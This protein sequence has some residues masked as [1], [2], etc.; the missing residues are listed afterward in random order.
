MAGIGLP[1]G[2]DDVTAEALTEALRSTG[3]LSSDGSVARFD[4]EQIGIGVGVLALLWRLTVEYE[5]A[6][7]GPATMVLKLPH[8]MPASRH[9]ADAFRFYLREVRFYEV[10]GHR[11]PLDTAD[12]YYS[13]YDDAS[14][15]FVLLM[16][17]F[18]DRRM[19]DQVTGVDVDDA[20]RVVT[21]L[22]RHHAEWWGSD[23]LAASDWAVRVQDPPNPQAL[24]PALRASWPI[25]ESQFSELLPGP[26]LAAAQ[27]MP[28]HVVSLMEQLSQPPLTLLHGDSR[29][30][31]FFFTDT[32]AV[33]DWQICGLGR[34][35]YDIAYFLSQSMRPELRKE[36]ERGLLE[37]YHR[38]LVDNGV[39]DYSFDDCWTDYRKAVLFVSVYPLNAGSVDLVNER[40]V[41]L[42]RMMLSRSSQ[43]ILDLDALEFLPDA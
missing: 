16:E 2:P 6:G 29:L 25:I 17:D 13:A 30:D 5:P 41:E 40:A 26:M 19:V 32:V 33:V 14:G 11:T 36:H 9:I 7:A 42:F 34:G 27:R 15:D 22:A 31:N 12:C 28:D 21:A 38:T 24:V 35:P 10:V 43:A 23:E 3:T 20:K 1:K 4:F 39:T 18:G 8:T 37:Q